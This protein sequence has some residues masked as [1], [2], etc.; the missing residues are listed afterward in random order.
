MISYSNSVM[1]FFFFFFFLFM[2]TRS[3][4]GSGHDE[5]CKVTRCKKKGP[6]IKFP[7]W[8][9]E[10][11]QPKRCRYP[12]FG[13][14]CTEKRETMLELSSS[15]KLLIDSIDYE[16]QVIK[17]YNPED[18]CSVLLQLLNLNL[19]DSLFKFE[20]RDILNFTMLKCSSSLPFFQDRC[21]DIAGHH[22]YVIPS[23]FSLGEISLSSCYKVKDISSPFTRDYDTH[24]PINFLY[25]RWSK[26]DCGE[27]EKQGKK[28][29]LNGTHGLQTICSPKRSHTS[30]GTTATALLIAAGILLVIV[31]VLAYSFCNSDEVDKE[32]QKKVEKFL[33]DYKALKPTRYSYA[34]IKRI[35]NQFKHTLGQGAYGTVFRG[36]LSDDIPVAVKILHNSKGNGEEF[37]NE[38]G[39]MATIHHVNVV[40]LLGF[41]ADGCNKAL[42]Y[43]FLPNESLEKFIFSADSKIPFLGWEKLQ[44]IA[45]GVA[46][47]IEYLHQGCNQRI[48]HFDIKPHNI[49]LDHNFNPKISDF[50]LAKLCSK[51]QSAVSMTVARGTLGYMAPEVLS[52]NFGNVSY[53]SD[54]YSFG[55]LLL[56]MVGGRKNIDD[57]V[58]NTSKVNFSEWIYNHLEQGE[59]LR[60]RIEEEGDAKIAKK[61][62]I[63]SLWCIQWYPADRPSMKVVVQMLEEEV[64]NL[65]MPPN[66]FAPTFLRN[67]NHAELPQRPL[68]QELEVISEIE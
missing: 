44:D 6:T 24:F 15:V 67:T 33:E 49:L 2:R 5:H 19:S 20:D 62:T 35:T 52:R 45:L 29:M 43:E 14:S 11:D 55:M 39:T 7:F 12:G 30:P 50:G 42:M 16:F 32:N 25:L 10:H 8:L 27:C 22:V 23:D 34:D 57:G 13:L 60:I 65:V 47:G 3:V 31:A 46:K 51:E 66:P 18:Y 9:K 1:Y 48:L 68:H 56:E 61:L 59:E 38:V 17:A 36:K 28:C 41:C 21:Q 54:V 40:R 64:D 53:K 37:I 58:K 63:V 4:V 26:P